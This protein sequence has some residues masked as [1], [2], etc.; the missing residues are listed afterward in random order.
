MPNTVPAI[1][2][3][4]LA[5]AAHG[6]ATA[7]VSSG[8]DFSFHDLLEIIN[9]LQHLPIIGTLYRAITGEHIGK[10]EKVAGDT[11]YGGLWG[12]ISSVADLA[13][14][15]VTGKD[16][17]DTVLSLLTG[18]HDGKASVTVAQ[19]NIIPSASVVTPDIAA[20]TTALAQKD[21]AG[22]PVTPP[23]IAQNSFTPR[24]APPVG[25]TPP[26]ISALTAALMQ[27]GIDSDITQRALL[28]YRRSNSLTDW[29]LANATGASL[30]ATVN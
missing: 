1:Y 26:D 12:A 11:L 22:D 5:N 13:F 20:L 6:A 24:A 23:G 19:N 27:K 4:G 17:G 10:F 3:P 18:H 9:P 14:E 16:F 21:F 30:L 29:P 2:T 15:A 8:L 25:A 28:A 7:H